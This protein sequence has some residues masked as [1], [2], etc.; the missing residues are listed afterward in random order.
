MLEKI[1]SVEDAEFRTYGRIIYD[2]DITEVVE[3]AKQIE[4]PAEGS[5]YLP[6]IDE[7]EKLEIFHEIEDKFYGTLSGQLGYCWGHN[8]VMNAMEYH[9]SHEINIAV[10]PFVLILGHIWDV[11][12]MK[13]DSNT[14]RAFYVPQ[15]TVLEIYATT[16]HFCPCQVSD[17]GF[18]CIVG[19]PRGTNVP[20]D[21]PVEAKPLFKQNKWVL[22]HEDN[23]SL[24]EKGIFPGITGENY[25]VQYEKQEG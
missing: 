22:A 15:G 11:E 3:A 5:S 8:Q 19:L 23:T 25:V 9:F 10:T 12:N 13:V 24:V 16:L 17:A 7:F 1:Y 2:L 6:S 4:N 14:F 18:G 20:I 21:G